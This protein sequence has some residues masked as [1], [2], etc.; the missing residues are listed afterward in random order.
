MLLAIGS[1]QQEL[2]AQALL[3]RGRCWGVALCIGAGLEFLVGARRRAPVPVQRLGLEWAYRLLSEPRRMWRRYLV[4][5]P[6]ILPLFLADLRRRRGTTP[7]VSRH[8]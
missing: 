6:R 7:R 1:P 3:R 2:F 5:G 8:A 4:D